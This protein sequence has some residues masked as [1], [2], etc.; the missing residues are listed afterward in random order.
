MLLL[1]SA[2]VEQHVTKVLTDTTLYESH[3]LST[4]WLIGMFA[5]KNSSSG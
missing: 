1:S 3:N 5:D 4:C 2:E